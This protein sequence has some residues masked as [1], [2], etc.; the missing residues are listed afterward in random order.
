MIQDVL[1][2]LSWPNWVFAILVVVAITVAYF[3]YHNTLPPLSRMRRL[4]VRLLR[5]LSLAILIF[6]ILEPILQLLYQ[7]RDK[8]VVA[9]LLD[10]SASMQ[11]RDNDG[12]RGDS[13]RY[14]FEQLSQVNPHD[15][16]DLRTYGFD[17]GLNRLTDDGL[18]FEA[19][20]SNLDRAIATLADSLAAE[21]LQGIILVSDGIYNQGANPILTAAKMPQPI[22]SIT[23]GDPSPPLDIAIQQVQTNQVTYVGNELP[24]ETVI[25]QNGY[26]GKTATLSISQNGRV[27]AQKEVRFEKDGFEQRIAMTLKPQEA[28]DFSY[29][30][31]LQGFKSE[32]TTNNN[33]KTVQIRVLKSKVR[34]AVLSGSPNFDRQFLSFV[35]EQ[36]EDYEFIFRTEQGGGN[37]FEG[38]L[39][40]IQQDSLDLFV[41]HG[42]PTRRSDP[43]QLSRLLQTIKQRKMPVLWLINNATDLQKLVPFREQLPFDIRGRISSN[44]N[45]VVALTAGGRMHPVTRIDDNENSNALIWQSLPPLEVFHEVNPRNGSQMLLTLASEEAGDDFPVCY[46]YRQDE[47]KQLVFNAANFGYWHFQLQNDPARDE[48]LAKFLERSVRWLVNRDDIHQIQIHPLERVVN[49]GEPVI[50]SGQVFDEFYN[51]LDDVQVV[52][53]VSGDTTRISDEMRAEGNGFFRYSLSGL[54]EGQYRYRITA[55]RKDQVIGTRSGRLSVKPFFLEFQQ[56][57]ANHDLMRKLADE[58]GGKTYTVQGF[59]DQFGQ[60]NFESRIRYTSSEYFVWSYWYWLVALVFFLGSEWF[61]RKRWGML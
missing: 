15:S 12:I 49:V 17:L 43:A 29:T 16:L 57:Q 3:Y 5:M 4:S 9:L 60:E 23:I 53:D 46:A 2:K 47:Q 6:L 8:P 7:N 24:V 27:V 59:L 45:Q 21:N 32:N 14:L 42:F 51:S 20:G 54:Q 31:G 58:T 34:V 13:I 28:G 44:E 50:F 10:N 1:L 41:L 11:I 30:V 25:W 22:H 38:R 37:Y 19:D 33:R 26:Q 39:N 40:E 35:S 36:L 18:K 56:L 48:F 61:L 52:V 55:K